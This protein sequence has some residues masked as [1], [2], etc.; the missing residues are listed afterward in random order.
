[1]KKMWVY[2]L[3]SAASVLKF[4]QLRVKSTKKWLTMPKKVL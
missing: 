4:C 2:L 1:M 3:I